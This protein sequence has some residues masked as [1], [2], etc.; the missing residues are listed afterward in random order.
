[1]ASSAGE[2]R[3][4]ED[5][6]ATDAYARARD[7]VERFAAGLSD[8]HRATLSSEPAVVAARHGSG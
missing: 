4:S 5:E 8:E 3:T 6:G 1:L 7:V 2:R